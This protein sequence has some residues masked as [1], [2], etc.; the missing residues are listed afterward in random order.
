M[1]GELLRVFVAELFYQRIQRVGVAVD[2][3]GVRTQSGCRNLLVSL[4]EQGL[5]HLT[6]TAHQ[7]SAVGGDLAQ[8]A[9]EGADVALQGR[10]AVVE[11]TGAAC[12]IACAA[13]QLACT[14]LQRRHTAVKLLCAVGQAAC[15]RSECGA[16][17]L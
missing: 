4:G 1:I 11:L 15:A 3:Q 2:G 12:Q 6:R 17:V 13:L 9:C 10:H 7:C 8:T 16:A 14:A 5:E